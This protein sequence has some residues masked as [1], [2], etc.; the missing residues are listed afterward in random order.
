[1]YN[2]GDFNSDIAIPVTGSDRMT[3]GFSPATMH[4]DPVTGIPFSQEAAQPAVTV[5]VPPA[6][7]G[8]SWLLVAA[9]ALGAW[10]AYKQ[11][12]FNEALAALGIHSTEVA[13]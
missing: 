13:E 1:M 4:V 6:S 2:L 5:V 9:L 8:V 12:W 7:S 10:Y 11:G 3:T